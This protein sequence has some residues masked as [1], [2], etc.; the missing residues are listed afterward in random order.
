MTLLL[1]EFSSRLRSAFMTAH[2]AA[3]Q[4]KPELFALYVC[5]LIY[6]RFKNTCSN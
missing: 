1:P 6:Q 2:P 3:Q 5:L 4:T